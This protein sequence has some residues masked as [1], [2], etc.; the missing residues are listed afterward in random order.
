[1][2]GRLVKRRHVRLA[3]DGDGRPSLASLPEPQRGAR[4]EPVR[5]GDEIVALHVHC[6]CG[7]Q[8]TVHLDYDDRAESPSEIS[9]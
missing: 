9:P 5:E 8:A 7:R 4:L 1:M 2:K 6:P 3:S